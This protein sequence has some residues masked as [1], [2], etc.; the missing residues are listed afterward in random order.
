[1]LARLDCLE[2]P[3][4]DKLEALRAAVKQTSSTAA[5]IAVMVDRIEKCEC[6]FGTDA[7]GPLREQEFDGE[8]LDLTANADH[9]LRFFGAPTI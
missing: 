2:A 3:H 1:M 6:L 4:V 9:S 5:L 8:I 7:W